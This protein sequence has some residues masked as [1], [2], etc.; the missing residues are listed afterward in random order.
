MA[1]TITFAGNTLRWVEQV[2]TSTCGTVEV[3]GT[4]TR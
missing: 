2:G 3:T 4:L 1:F